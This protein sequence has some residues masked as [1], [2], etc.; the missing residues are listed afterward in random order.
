VWVLGGAPKAVEQPQKILVRVLSWA[1]TS[2][3]MTGVN[4][5]VFRAL[6]NVSSEASI[7]VIPA[8]AGIQDV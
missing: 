5:M 1:W 6:F 7:D 3:P 8:Q 4:S 2:S